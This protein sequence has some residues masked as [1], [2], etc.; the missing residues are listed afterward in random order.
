MFEN[1]K[2]GEYSDVNLIEI[3]ITFVMQGFVEM[4]TFIMA[5]YLQSLH[6]ID[7]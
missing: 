5:L 2:E 3:L 4:V 1:E 6:S 7:Y